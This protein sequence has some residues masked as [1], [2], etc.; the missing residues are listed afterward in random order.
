LK[1]YTKH[2]DGGISSLADGKALPKNAPA[3]AAL[4]DLDEVNAHIGLIKN[5][6]LNNAEIALLE[7]IQTWI[8]A[9]S[10]FLAGVD[11]LRTQ[12]SA[13][14]AAQL[15]AAIDEMDA[16]VP[17]PK[18][19]VLPGTCRVGA[20]IDIAR[21]VTRRAERSIAAAGS[22]TA[23]LKR[24]VN[25]LSDYLYMLAR[26]YDFVQLIRQ[27]VEAETSSLP[28][29]QA[30]QSESGLTLQTAKT[31]VEQ[32][33]AEAKRRHLPAVI[34]LCDASGRPIAVH[35]MDNAFLVSFDVAV[36]KAYTAVAVKMKTEE[37]AKLAQPGGMFFGLETANDKMMIIGG[38]VPLYDN[39]K[40]VGGLGISGGTAEQDIALAEFG[41]RAFAGGESHGV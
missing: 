34:S 12:I 14:W 26:Y 6:S 18:V 19:F 9:A 20:Q 17:A 4:G 41:L 31:L 23:E 33:E 28:Q 29:V 5:L 8:I 22:A 24:F 3:F 30:P 37:L 35:V 25:R 13:D 7:N 16:V 1:V 39:D 2:G 11:S 15:E 36:K 40:L 27:T 10:G 32:I 21:T 38:G